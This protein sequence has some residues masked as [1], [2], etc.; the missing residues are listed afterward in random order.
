MCASVCVC[1]G[2]LMYVNVCVSACAHM[3][4]FACVRLCMHEHVLLSMQ[5]HVRLDKHEHVH[6]KLHQTMHDMGKPAPI[7]PMVNNGG[8]SSVKDTPPP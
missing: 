1:A 6:S 8:V 4:G 7:N 2:V 5:E 3:C